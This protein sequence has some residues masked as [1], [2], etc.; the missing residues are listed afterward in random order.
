M[1]PISPFDPVNPIVPDK[2]ETKLYAEPLHKYNFEFSELFTSPVSTTANSPVSI[3]V[4]EVSAVN[5]ATDE[6]ILAM[7]NPKPEFPCEPVKPTPCE[8]V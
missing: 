5:A 2:S 4:G 7:L 6:Y 3:P 8:P 1:Y